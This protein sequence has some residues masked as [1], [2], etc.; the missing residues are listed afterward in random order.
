MRSPDVDLGRD[1]LVCKN[2]YPLSVIGDSLDYLWST[3]T[4]DYSLTP[5]YSDTYAVTVKNKCGQSSDSIR[6]YS[7]ADAFIPNVITIN[8]DGLNEK[9]RIAIEEGPSKKINPEP[10][11]EGQLRIYNKWGNEIF[12]DPSY[13]SDWPKPTDDLQGIYYYTFSHANCPAIKGWVQVIR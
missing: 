2:F 6:V 8:N 12:Y 4:S 13:K 11:I 10:G 1:T 3:G 5:R 9:L 7:L